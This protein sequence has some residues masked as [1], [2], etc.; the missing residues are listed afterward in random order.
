MRI[1]YVDGDSANHP[2]W[3]WQLGNALMIAH[4][5]E[6]YFE[7]QQELRNRH[8][9]KVIMFLDMTNGPGYVYIPTRSAYERNAYQSWQTLL[10]PGAFEDMIEKL[11][12]AITQ[13][14]ET[15]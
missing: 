9:D 1:D 7:M 13:F 12:N 15:V 6:A 4:P 10:A 14:F 2:V 11:D 8:S 5:G 3:L